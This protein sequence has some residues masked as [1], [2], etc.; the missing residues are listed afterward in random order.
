M[1]LGANAFASNRNLSSITIPEKFTDIG[2]S[3]FEYSL[4]LKN[5]RDDNDIA[6]YNGILIDGTTSKGDVTISENVTCIAGEAFCKCDDLRSVTIS[7]G[8]VRIGTKAF[9]DCYN[10]S[11]VIIPDSVTEIG[12]NAFD[13]SDRLTVIIS[14][15]DSYAAQ[16]A[17]TNGI[18][19]MSIDAYQ[20]SNT[21]SQP[22][23]NVETNVTEIDS[24]IT[25]SET[26]TVDATT[27]ST[28]TNPKITTSVATTSTITPNQSASDAQ[29]QTTQTKKTTKPTVAKVTKFKATAKENGFTLQWKKITGASGYQIQVS[30]KKNFKRAKTYEVKKTKYTISKLTSKTK[31]FIRI[32]AYK[33]YKDDNGKTQKAYG[34]YVS[35]SKS[36]K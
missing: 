27:S 30:T 28:T 19:W 21:V 29:N 13:S 14:S 8:V 10:L 5:Q 7:Q 12:E 22:T 36:T 18:K 4:W 11:S 26:P 2:T 33:T 24:T 20:Q 16:Y 17:K 1:Y 25:G 15:E 6:V 32:R 35:L 3:V 23:D 31:Y 9:Y 34:K